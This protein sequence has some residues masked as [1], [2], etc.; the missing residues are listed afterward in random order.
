MSSLSKK[1]QKKRKRQAAASLKAEKKLDSPQNIGTAIPL[2]SK[3]APAPKRK[4]EPSPEIDQAAENEEQG[5]NTSRRKKA[6]TS[7]AKK[8]SADA[9]EQITQVVT[10][11]ETTAASVPTRRFI[12]F[13]GNL[14]FR[15]TVD[16]VKTLLSAHETS[17]TSV[18]MPKDI[19]TKKPNGYAFVE[20]AD[21]QSLRFALRMHQTK[22][23]ERKINVELTAGGGGKSEART[24]KIKQRNESLQEERNQRLTKR[25]AELDSIREKQKAAGGP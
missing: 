19:K 20:F 17:V 13:V 24:T 14:P 8:A 12:A 18:R 16:A 4:L 3:S 21:A 22:V 7:R 15:I 11:T 9:N 5:N 2:N 23:G 6:L 1:L 10:D 25:K